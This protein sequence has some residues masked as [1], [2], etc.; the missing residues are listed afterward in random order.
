M[1]KY[2]TIYLNGIKKSRKERKANYKQYSGYVICPYQYVYIYIF[3]NEDW[4]SGEDELGMMA[5][6]GCRCLQKKKTPVI[7]PC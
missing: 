3:P 4:S 2:I 6:V 7:I 1:S 5:E